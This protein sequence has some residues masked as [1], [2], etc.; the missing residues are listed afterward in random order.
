KDADGSVRY[1][2]QHTVD[3]TELHG[4]RRLRDEMGIVARAQAVQERNLDL[5]TESQQLKYLFEQA[6]GF[7]AML[8]GQQH[9]FRMANRAYLH[10]VGNREIIGI[11]VAEALP[12]VVDQGF[13]ALL[14]RVYSSGEAYVGEG[15]PVTL[16]NLK[17]EAERR[18]LNFIY[19]PIR[20]DAGTVSGVLVQ[21]HDVTDHV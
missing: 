2:L 12:E 11:P 9:V 19:Q 1:V 17:G 5:A 21:G 16:R 4:L 18:F 6:P 3:V 7:V 15:T 13:I 8:G 14:D 10:L 20:D